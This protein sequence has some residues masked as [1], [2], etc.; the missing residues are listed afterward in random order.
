MDR[1]ELQLGPYLL[2][3]KH[4][5]A[6]AGDGTTWD[7]KVSAAPRCKAR[8]EGRLPPIAHLGREEENRPPFGQRI[9]WIGGDNRLPFAAAGAIASPWTPLVMSTFPIS[10]QS[11]VPPPLL[12]HPHGDFASGNRAGNPLANLGTERAYWSGSCSKELDLHTRLRP[13]EHVGEG[14]HHRLVPTA[15]RTCRTHAS[16]ETRKDK[17]TTNKN[18]ELTH[19]SSP[20]T[21]TGGAGEGKRNGAA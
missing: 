13:S 9:Q 18:N 16:T 1:G 19:P 15:A 5:L 20:P 2:P 21:P 3:H 12:V 7:G 6:V 4:D 17:E 10:N 11:S 14:E 8:V